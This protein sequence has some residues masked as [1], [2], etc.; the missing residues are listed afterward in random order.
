[1]NK[2]ILL[3][4]EQLIKELDSNNYENI[5]NDLMIY[6]RDAYKHVDKDLFTVFLK[7]DILDKVD[8]KINEVPQKRLN[9]RR[10]IPNRIYLDNL[11]SFK[12]EII[13][14]YFPFL[15]GYEEYSVSNNLTLLF[16]DL[17]KIIEKGFECH[18]LFQEKFDLFKNKVN[19]HY[20]LVDDFRFISNT[21][22]CFYEAILK[23]KIKYQSQID[24]NKDYIET[25]R[26]KFDNN[27]DVVLSKD[28][29]NGE[30]KLNDFINNR[31]EIIL[32]LQISI[33]QI[34]Y[35]IDFFLKKDKFIG[36]QIIF[37]S[38]VLAYTG[39]E[40]DS[41]FNDLSK[42]DENVEPI[43][44]LSESHYTQLI[45]NESILIVNGFLL[46]YKK[47]Y[48]WINTKAKICE[49]CYYFSENES[50]NIDTKYSTFVK[51]FFKRYNIKITKQDL[52]KSKNT[53][54]GNSIFKELLT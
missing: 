35:I 38:P 39:D 41:V 13:N 53:Y 47:K 30:Y 44:L 33:S 7:I 18:H 21:C 49:L 1:M 5:L 31:N 42:Y 14:L 9:N 36:N 51:F 54:Y 45:K 22:L 50:S 40:L 28:E 46:S 20:S 10:G 34:D 26:E 2:N 8:F 37:K 3:V 17:L 48:K 4:I 16:D 15:K 29:I 32:E 6:L 23:E 11:N 25:Y 52:N 27:L 19:K 43:Y 24:L 12:Q